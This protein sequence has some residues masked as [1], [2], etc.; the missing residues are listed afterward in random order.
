MEH[1]TFP[2]AVID[3]NIISMGGP[4]TR[5]KA[6]DHLLHYYTDV[7]S[8]TGSIKN[9]PVPPTTM[10]C[11]SSNSSRFK[12][13]AD[14][15]HRWLERTQLN[16]QEHSAETSRDAYNASRQKMSS[17]RPVCLAR[18]LLICINQYTKFE[19]LSF[20]DYKDMIGA[21]FI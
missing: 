20:T 13:H 14:E 1:P 18:L 16:L 12:Q 11:L 17:G 3:R 6:V 8:V 9:T 2:G 10:T 19:V 5:S 21:K 7:L 4:N 15:E